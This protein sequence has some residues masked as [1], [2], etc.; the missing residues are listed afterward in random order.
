MESGK[1]D[2]P[3]KKYN[4]AIVRVEWVIK[5]LEAARPKLIPACR[6]Q[7]TPHLVHDSKT[8]LTILTITRSVPTLYTCTPQLSFRQGNNNR[9][10]TGT[11]LTR[12]Q[13]RKTQ[14]LY[15]CLYYLLSILFLNSLVSF[16]HSLFSIFHSLFTSLQSLFSIF[17]LQFLVSSLQSIVSS[18][19]YLY[20]RISSLL[21]WMIQHL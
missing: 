14:P 5:R 12:I 3:K 13:L 21:P 11:I 6:L 8:D 4:L 15:S 7:F 2:N 16:R 17:S 9:S 20:S 19:Q 18:L 1:E 10:Q